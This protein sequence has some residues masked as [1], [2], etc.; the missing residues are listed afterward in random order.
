MVLHIGFVQY[1]RGNRMV[2]D[3]AFI[4]SRT[5]QE[6]AY[7]SYNKYGDFE[8]I[9]SAVEGVEVFVSAAVA[10]RKINERMVNRYGY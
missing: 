5:G 10:Y 8:V 7:G 3:T 6:I 9:G 2:P 4:E 1:P